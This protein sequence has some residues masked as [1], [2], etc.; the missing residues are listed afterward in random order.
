[1]TDLSQGSR[2]LDTARGNGTAARNARL[3]QARWSLSRHSPAE[4]PFVLG[5]L[6]PVNANLLVGLGVLWR[7]CPTHLWVARPASS[8]AIRESTDGN[9]LAIRAIPCHTAPVT[10]PAESSAAAASRP[11]SKTQQASLRRQAA[12]IEKGKEL[13]ATEWERSL[14][15]LRHEGK[16]GCGLM[17][18]DRDRDPKGAT[19]HCPRCGKSGPLAAA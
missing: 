13:L 19:Y 1:M 12:E 6:S 4:H 8:G 7:G 9:T 11:P 18:T 14:V 17:L 5:L 16:C 2:R 15:L 10:K 3:P